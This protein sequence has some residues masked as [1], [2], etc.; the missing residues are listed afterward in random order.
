MHK[1][2]PIARLCGVD[3]HWLEHARAAGSGRARAVPLLA[4]YLGC[5]I[6]RVLLETTPGGRPRLAC[7]RSPLDFNLAHAGGRLL[8]ALGPGRFGVDVE[9]LETP[10][11]HLALARHQFEGGHGGAANNAQ[12]AHMSALAYTFLWKQLK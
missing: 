1:P 10:R 12:Q 9:S 6:E 5:P 7:P 3:L 4:E 11:D 8:L 2:E